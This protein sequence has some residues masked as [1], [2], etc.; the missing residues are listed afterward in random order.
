MDHAAA[1]QFM[2]SRPLATG[3]LTGWLLGDPSAGVAVGATLEL[4]SLAALPVGASRLPD[5]TA[6]T[7]AAVV[8]ASASTGAVGYALGIAFGL[9]WGRLG[10]TTVGWTRAL[11]TRFAPEPP[12]IL[13][14]GGRGARTLQRIHLVCVGVEFVRGCALTFL[15]AWLGVEIAL[16]AGPSWPLSDS[17][18]LLFLLMGGCV[19]LGILSAS[20]ADTRRRQGLLALGF[21]AGC[22]AATL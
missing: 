19:S 15:G 14:K 21:L 5:A 6:G 8:C 4:Y 12:A 7:I 20:I 16:R 17:A 18:T 9:A 3:A 2:V 11:N 13:A 22:T 10:Q 1:G